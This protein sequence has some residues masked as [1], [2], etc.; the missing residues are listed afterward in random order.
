MLN[1]R[2]VL[3]D[4][5]TDGLLDTCTLVWIITIQDLDTNEIK[6]WLPHLGDTGWREWM[7]NAR[8][9]VGHNI[10]G[11]DFLALRKIYNWE[12]PQGCNINDTLIMSQ[13]LNYKRF[14]NGGHSLADWGEFFGQ[15]KVEHEDWSKYSP[16]MR[17]R[18]ISDVH[19]N[20]RVYD[21]L[22][23]ESKSVMIA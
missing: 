14:S 12:M 1:R 6:T 20:R 5:E 2:R 17:H 15:P 18:N 8:L 7:D 19:L 16:E 9:I 4:I 13:V 11:F 3:F 23:D 10:I 22:L 21:Y